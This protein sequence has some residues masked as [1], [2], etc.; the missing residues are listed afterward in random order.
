VYENDALTY[1]GS[2]GTGFDAKKL[3]AIAAKLGPLERKTSAFANPPKTDTKAHWVTP[4]LVAEVTFTE[5]TRD[6]QMRHP[7]F[8]ALR[9]DRD[10][11]EIGRE[12]V[13]SARDVA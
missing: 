13:T 2:V 10:P 4:A 1:V 7:V 5:W 3:A 11:R 12:R 8:V 9:S 6:G